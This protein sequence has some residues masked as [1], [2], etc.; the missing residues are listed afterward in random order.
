MAE[1]ALGRDELDGDDGDEREA[2]P[3]AQPG[4]DGRQRAGQ[5]H[6]A[7]ERDPARAVVPAHLD[8]PRVEA[9]HAAGRAEHDLEE[10]RHRPGQ[11]ERGLAHAE[12]NQ[13]ERQQRDL[14]QRIPQRD[15]R[16]DRAPHRPPQAHGE[17]E[18]H[19]G[20]GGEHE[21]GAE[22]AQRDQRF[23]PEKAAGDEVDQ[24]RRDGA[25][26]REVARGDEAE[27]RGRLPR[28][29]EKPGTSP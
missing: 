26:R 16:L 20:H 14:R 19:R 15:V 25:R 29:E 28:G 17:T 1:P 13:E 27:P 10:R 11:H 5:D 23:L 3:E 21:R 8:Q 7:K 9:R 24:R 6:L 4:E 12:Q 18:R 22:T 2:E